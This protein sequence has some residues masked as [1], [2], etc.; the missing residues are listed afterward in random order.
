MLNQFFRSP[1]NFLNLYLD[2][3]SK[4]RLYIYVYMQ[5]NNKIF[6]IRMFLI[7]NINQNLFDFKVE[8]DIEDI[9]LTFI[10]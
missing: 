2:D 5:S 8:F 6:F 3:I 7:F 4:V 1:S 10:V 9:K